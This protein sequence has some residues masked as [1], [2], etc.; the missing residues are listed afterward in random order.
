M[1]SSSSGGFESCLR[2]CIPVVPSTTCYVSVIWRQHSRAR[3]RP[4]S[5]SSTPCVCSWRSAQPW[6][7][8]PVCARTSLG[9]AARRSRLTHRWRRSVV[10]AQPAAH[11]DVLSARRGSARAARRRATRPRARFAA[12]LLERRRVYSVARLGHVWHIVE[13]C[14][15]TRR[16]SA[17]RAGRRGRWRR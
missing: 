1:R 3:K 4:I 6:T 15:R 5:T 16:T 13:G 12:L 11:P 7:R 17:I 8:P 2:R 10:R 14:T 9:I